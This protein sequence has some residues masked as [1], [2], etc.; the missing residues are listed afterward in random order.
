M[1]DIDIKEKFGTGWIGGGPEERSS[2]AIGAFRRQADQ[3]FLTLGKQMVRF[4]DD[5]E[6]KEDRLLN[7]ASKM[8]LEPQVVAEVVEWL[9]NNYYVQVEVDKFGNHTIRLTERAKELLSA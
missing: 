2:G 1:S 3:T 4:L 9:A 7:L 6:G 8:K 5:S